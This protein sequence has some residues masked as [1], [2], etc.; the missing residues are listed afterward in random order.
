MHVPLRLQHTTT[1]CAAAC[2]AMVLGAFGRR[3][4]VA[5]VRERMPAGRSGVSGRALLH[6]GTEYGLRMRAVAASADS[7]AQLPMPV[8]AYWDDNHYVVV[9]RVRRLDVTVAD[10]AVGKVRMPRSEFME[11]YSGVAMCAEPG[12]DGLAPRLDRAERH[13]VRRLLAGSLG[14]KRTA[15]ALV[16]ASLLVQVFTLLIPLLTIAATQWAP[17]GTLDGLVPM[18]AV[19]VG[20]AVASQGAAAR[21]RSLLFAQVH[22]RAS[23]AVME[24]L[25]GHT[26]SLPY[27]FFEQRTAGDLIS[28]FGAVSTLREL[29]TERSFALL[30]DSVMGL[31]FLAVVALESPEIALVTALVGVAQGLVAVL[32]ARA[33][34]RHSQATLAAQSSSQSAL[35]EALNGIETIKACGGE[36]AVLSRWRSRYDRELG[37]ARRRDRHLAG[38]QA[39]TGALQFGLAA[40]LLV[41]IAHIVRTSD[42]HSVSELLAY[43]AFAGSAL[44]PLASLLTTVQQLNL[45]LAHVDRLGDVVGAAPEPTGGRR[46]G[47]DLT[48]AIELHGVGFSYDGGEQVLHDIDLR[49]EAGRRVALV[50]ASGS[51]KT[52]LG[53]VLLGL[54]DATEGEVRF[55]GVP[56][57][58]LDRGWLR[59]RVGAV[60]QAPFLLAGSIADNIALG[61]GE[62]APDEVMD[63][64]RLAAIDEDI[65]RMPMTYGTDV[66][67]GGG[68]L[69]GGQRQRLALAR[70]LAG[71]PRILLLDEP[72][73]SLD[74]AAEDTVR[75]NLAELG[76]TQLV[77][78]HRL[79]TIRDADLIVVLE[80]GRIVETGTHDDLLH[81]GGTYATLVARQHEDTA[82][83]T[84]G[85]RDGS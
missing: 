58:E 15:A 36:G 34:L 55:D 56:L 59:E 46:P 45:A 2:L 85:R 51:G 3:T 18:L 81:R 68:R 76:C 25:V 65:A 32:G 49:V 5:E 70:A 24:R 64:A 67:E 79:S 9:E 31:G 40:G 20:C 11:R 28:R 6:T 39:A 80:A 21:M 8:I 63:A 13:P 37:A 52:T 61:H 54:L 1:D 10:P 42:T 12:P 30:F 73:S 74:A 44:A 16:G 33:S 50:G 72:T 69:S 29:L 47:T 53:R 26:L 14:G 66:G 27:A 77:I 71:R 75:R 41:A 60:P 17:M 23:G 84:S 62:L 4:T 78:A 22:T 48:G 19:W 35:V 43:A 57:P 38:I 82:L 83:T 7:V